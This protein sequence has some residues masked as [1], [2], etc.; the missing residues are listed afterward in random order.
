M[1]FA[2]RPIEKGAN[3]D[4]VIFL[5]PRGKPLG[6]LVWNSAQFAQPMLNLNLRKVFNQPLAKCLT[7]NAETIS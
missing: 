5:G 6:A 3:G 2:D 7:K 4:E 1:T